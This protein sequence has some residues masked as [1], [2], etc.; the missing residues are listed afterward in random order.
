MLASRT[1]RGGSGLAELDDVA[2]KRNGRLFT[3]RSQEKLM[4][5]AI[6]PLR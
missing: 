2:G 4:R 3:G 5:E 6:R 1:R